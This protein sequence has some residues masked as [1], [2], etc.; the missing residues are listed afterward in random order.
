MKPPE[1]PKARIMLVEDEA[2]VALDIKNKLISLGYSV[3]SSIGSAEECIRKLET[4]RVDLVLMDISLSGHMDGI[5]AAIFIKGKYNIPVVFL[6]AHNDETTLQRAKFSGPYG[7]ILKPFEFRDLRNNIEISLYKHQMEQKLLESEKA[8]QKELKARIEEQNN[9]TRVIMEKL[10]EERSRISR[11]LHDSIGQM[12]FALKFNLEVLARTNRN[13]ITDD[14]LQESIRLVSDTNQ[15]LKNIIYSLHPVVID[16]Y[17][18]YAATEKLCNDFSAMKG[19]KINFLFDNPVRYDSFKEMNIYRII[20][21]ALTNIARHS[22]ATEADVFLE[23]TDEYFNIVIRDNG[24]GF[25]VDA[26]AGDSDFK[27]FGIVNIRQRA[28]ILRAD[29]KIES[30]PGSGTVIVLKIPGS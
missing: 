6:T 9:H 13:T 4:I 24:C 23:C 1:I 5:D 17:G 20:Q 14:R 11:E 2:I 8:I 12:L 18:L 27:G 21:E 30:S 22:G 29:L 10:E 7:Y 15:E 28:E 25:S 3:E 16:N 19:I 26:T